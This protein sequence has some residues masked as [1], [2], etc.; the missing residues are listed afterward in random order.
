MS[1][2]F[3]GYQEYKGSPSR[4][5]EFTLVYGSVHRSD[6]KVAVLLTIGGGGPF[7][8]NWSHDSKTFLLGQHDGKVR[9]FSTLDGKEIM[10]KELTGTGISGVALS[11]DNKTVVCR[12]SHGVVFLDRNTGKEKH[13]FALIGGQPLAFSTD[14][15]LL[16]IGAGGAHGEIWRVE[17]RS[18][19]GKAVVKTIT[20]PHNTPQF[21]LSWSPDSK[22]LATAP[23]A[24]FSDCDGLIRLWDAATGKLNATLL[25]LHDGR[26]LAVSAQGHF[27]GTPPKA[28]RDREVVYVFQTDKGIET[29]SPDEFEKRFGWANDPERVRPTGK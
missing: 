6:G 18:A 14:G 12:I 25:P 27:L 21:Q 20:Q 5:G 15:N 1:G 11:P 17:I 4:N 24:Q 22:T 7:V 26:G 8:V 28:V 19:D 2:K 23:Q 29:L 9:L 10:T 13:Q 3:L 16:A